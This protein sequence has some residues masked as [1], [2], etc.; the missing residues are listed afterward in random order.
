VVLGL[1]DVPAVAD[2]EVDAPARQLIERCD[3]LRRVDRVALGTEVDARAQPDARRHGRRG[4]EGDD[5][6]HRAP[7]LLRQ[8]AGDGERRGACHRDVG[9]VAADVQGLQATLLG[10]TSQIRDPRGLVARDDDDADVH[11]HLLAWIGAVATP[12]VGTN[13]L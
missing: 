12:R 9:V 11:G 7:V 5:R 3:L 4:G 13:W 1:L 6:I 10:G 2:T 8:V